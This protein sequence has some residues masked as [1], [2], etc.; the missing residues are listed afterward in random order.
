MARLEFYIIYRVMKRMKEKNV[1]EKSKI[2][3]E[4]EEKRGKNSKEEVRTDEQR[5]RHQDRGREKEG[6]AQ[7]E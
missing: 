4:K 3:G 7:E 1:S 6:K 5:D 2:N